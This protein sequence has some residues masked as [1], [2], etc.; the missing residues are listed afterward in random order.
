LAHHL[1]RG[2]CRRIGG[3]GWAGSFDHVVEVQQS[4]NRCAGVLISEMDGERKQI[5][6][7]V[8]ILDK[9]DQVSMIVKS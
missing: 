5:E 8:G 9:E 1:V 2:S 6:I 7:N 4:K 3:G